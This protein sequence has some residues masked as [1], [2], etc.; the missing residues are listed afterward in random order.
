VKVGL[1]GRY[2][3]AYRP[4]VAEEILAFYAGEP[5]WDRTLDKFP[6]DLVLV[7]STDP[8]SRLLAEHSGWRC[9]YQDDAFEV[10]ARPG[11][12]L[13]YADSRGK[14]IEPLFP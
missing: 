7:R 14:R 4:G 1:D 3:V 10:L 9:V 8:V 2:E 6:A 5:G 13:P 11:L 12:E